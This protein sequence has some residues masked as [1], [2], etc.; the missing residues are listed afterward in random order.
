[1]TKRDPQDTSASNVRASRMR[2]VQRLIHG[3][4]PP[5]ARFFYPRASGRKVHGGQRQADVLSRSW[6]AV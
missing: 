6:F 1:M 5:L 4:L 2:L 3:R